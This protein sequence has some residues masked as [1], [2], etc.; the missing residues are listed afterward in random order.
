MKLPNAA[1]AFVDIN[2]LRGYSL[3]LHHGRGK[4]KAKLFAA[5]LG[6]TADDAEELQ[7]ILLQAIIE[8]EA[9]PTT[10]DQYGQRY[11]VEFPL[12]RND[13]TATIRSAWIIRP[14]ETFPRLVSCYIVRE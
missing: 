7:A 3:N 5:I 4:H 11:L 14:S 10:Q 12:T 6:L 2:K 8:F 13:N 1:D 9:T